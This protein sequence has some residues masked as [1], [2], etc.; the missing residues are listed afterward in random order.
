MINFMASKRSQTTVEEGSLRSAF[1]S[2][3]PGV[4]LTL[5]TLVVI[6]AQLLPMVLDRVR[7]TLRKHAHAPHHSCRT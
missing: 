4:Y 6:G 1:V 3:I 7:G 5:M 2:I